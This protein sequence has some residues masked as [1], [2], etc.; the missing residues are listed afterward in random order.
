MVAFPAEDQQSRSAACNDQF[1]ALD[2]GKRLERGTRSPPALRAMAVERVGETVLHRV[3]DQATQATACQKGALCWLG[4][5]AQGECRCAAAVIDAE[6][7]EKAAASFS[8]GNAWTG[9]VCEVLMLF[10]ELTARSIVRLGDCFFCT[11]RDN[12]VKH[13]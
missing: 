9:E 1:L 10:I 3:L 6:E 13:E 4:L 5:S 8:P 7:R 2:A 11:K 12:H